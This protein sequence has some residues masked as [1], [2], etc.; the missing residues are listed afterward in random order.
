MGTMKPQPLFALAVAVWALATLPIVTA[1]AGDRPNVVLFLADDLGWTGLRCFGSDFYETPNLDR[2]AEDGMKFTDAYAACTVC[3]PSRAALM[4]GMYPARLHLTS[5]IPGQDRPFARMNIPDWNKG[6]D[7]NLTTVAE[8]LKQG[9]YRTLHVGKWHLNYPG[10]PADPTRH[11]FD[12]SEDKPPRTKGYYLAEDVVKKLGKKTNYLTDHLADLAVEQI[13]KPSDDPFFLYFAFHVPHTPIQGRDDLVADFE[14][15]VDPDA[16]HRNPVYAAMVKSM[17]LAVGRVLDALE[18][19]GIADETIVIFTSD[20]GGLTQRYGVHD[21]FTENLPLRRGKGSAYEGGVR[22]PLIVKWPGV[23]PAGSVCDEP[24]MGIDF[25]PTLLEIAGIEGDANHNASIDGVSLTPLFRKPDT[26]FNRELY[27]H[28]PHYHAGGDSP[29]ST[30]RS[31]NYR[32]VEFHETGDLELYDLATD[33]GESTNLAAQRPEVA[34]ELH[35][36]LKQWRIDVAAQMPTENP[37]FDPKR[38]TVVG[39]RSPKK[40]KA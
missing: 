2:L 5:F 1:T 39:K 16:V 32:L 34:S 15:K 28:F 3:S 11:G 37:N 31:K 20:N 33:P 26:K 30:V 38:A 8:A 22:V 14:R 10:K 6:L 35:Q 13:S 7:P 27:W 4:T 21:N 24:V 19:Q 12:S 40:P 29:Y 36:K 17:D 23:T 9:G 25:Y 18:A